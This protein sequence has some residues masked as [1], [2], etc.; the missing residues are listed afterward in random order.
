MRM[1]FSIDVVT[2]SSRSSPA[3]VSIQFRLAAL[4]L[5]T[6]D[7][8]GV[9]PCDV[10]CQP[11]GDGMNVFLPAATELHRA[12]PRLVR[13]WDD[14]LAADNQRFRDRLRL[15]MAV[16]VGPVCLTPLGFG[17]STIVQVSRLLDSR[18]LR[19]AVCDSPQADLAVLVSDQI[20]RYVIGEGYPGLGADAFQHRFVVLDGCKTHTWLW[21]SCRS[22]RR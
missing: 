19:R 22:S 11:T 8:M 13:A 17:G 21:I 4:L 3:K 6:L 9:D 15:R 1:G 16:V 7:E 18:A 10:D 12:L 20:Y 2:Y 14:C 5:A